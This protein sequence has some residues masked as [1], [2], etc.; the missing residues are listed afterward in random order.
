MSRSESQADTA[1][2]RG[3][4]GPRDPEPGT[5][6]ASEPRVPTSDSPD[7]PPH[8]PFA[9]SPDEYTD[10]PGHHRRG[11]NGPALDVGA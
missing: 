6:A 8:P 1:G 4:A 7:T 10:E 5:E 9:R 3:T 2:A 11:P